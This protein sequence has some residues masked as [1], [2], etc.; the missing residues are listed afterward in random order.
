M[1]LLRPV[2]MSLKFSFDKEKNLFL[3]KSS[4]SKIGYYYNIE[5]SNRYIFGGLDGLA[6][7][8]MRSIS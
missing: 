2:D 3:A 1:S 7:N 4:K 5:R 6:K 8:Y